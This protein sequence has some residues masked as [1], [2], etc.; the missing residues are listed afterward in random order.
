VPGATVV[1]VTSPA[2]S[3]ASTFGVSDPRLAWSSTA[4]TLALVGLGR[5]RLLQRAALAIGGVNRVAGLRAP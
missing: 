5:K 4:A 3:A 2:V 1:G